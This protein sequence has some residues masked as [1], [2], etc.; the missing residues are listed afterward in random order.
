MLN[1]VP[2][3]FSEYKPLS[4]PSQS[5]KPH[6]SA[7][8]NTSEAF[9][10]LF[11]TST[12]FQLIANYTNINAECKRATETDEEKGEA[13]PWRDTTGAE[14]GVFLGILMLQGEYR[15]PKTTDYW[16]EAIDKAICLPILTAMSKD[17][18]HQL[19]RYLKISNL[20]TDLDFSGPQWYTKL[21]PLYSDFIN[22]SQTYM[23]PGRD[24]SVNEQLILFKGCSRHT[25]N[26]GTKAASHGFKIYSLCV[27]NYLYN[28]LFTSK[29]SKISLLE[30]MK[31]LSVM[32]FGLEIL[33]S[34]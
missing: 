7:T 19:K 16:N 17:R 33:T 23:V 1:D 13:K 6:I 20:I 4:I 3:C 9:F 34:G 21:K 25:M 29:A 18:W 8:I 2:A 30:K 22:S 10:E 5:S 27:Q 11:V 12:H 24:V 32:V 31:G 26:M 15:L 14:I 28:F